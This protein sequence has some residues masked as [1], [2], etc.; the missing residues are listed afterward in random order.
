MTQQRA[1]LPQVADP[2][3]VPETLCDGPFYV[4]VQGDLATLTL[5]HARPQPN[6]LFGNA[7]N[8]EKVVRAR[9]CGLG[10]VMGPALQT[11][12]P[13]PKMRRLTLDVASRVARMGRVEPH[14]WRASRGAS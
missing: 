2:D 9:S 12:C 1:T 11:V 7:I 8:M 6:D 3:S 5:T 4:H 10:A 13:S 14:T